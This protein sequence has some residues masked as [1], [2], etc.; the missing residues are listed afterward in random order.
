MTHSRTVPD[1]FGLYSVLT[2]P[3][4]GYDYVTEVLVELEVPFVQ[5]RMKNATPF[6]VLKQAEILRKI[7]EGSATRFIVND[8]PEVARDAA[9]DGVHIGQDDMSYADV[10]AIVGEHALIGI[11]THN[12]TQ[13]AEACELG[14]DYIGVGP[15]YA[16]PTKIIADPVLGLVTMQKMLE[17]STVPAVAIGGISLA[18]LS[19]V[20]EAGARNVCMVRPICSA[21]DPRRVVKEILRIYRESIARL[22]G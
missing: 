3:L 16:T 13:T 19:D 6:A 4:R 15:V 7:T 21:E 14:P 8:H 12:P 10:R 17:R 5:L 18:Y 22:R 1:H 2:D 9:A 11:S 20:L